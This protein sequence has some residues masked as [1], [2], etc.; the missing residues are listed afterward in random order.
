MIWSY[1]LPPK[2]KQAA[3]F[4]SL[5]AWRDKMKGCLCTMYNQRLHM[6]YF[7]IQVVRQLLSFCSNL[8]IFNIY[9]AV[10]SVYFSVLFLSFSLR[11]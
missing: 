5:S 9:L 6:L 2:I 11:V 1:L 10:L 4:S 8:F 3:R 7:V